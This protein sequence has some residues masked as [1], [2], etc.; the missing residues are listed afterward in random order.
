[1]HPHRLARFVDVTPPGAASAHGAAVSERLSRS[2]PGTNGQRA[3]V[4]LPILAV[5]GD[6]VQTASGPQRLG[7]GKGPTLTRPLM[8]PLI[9]ASLIAAAA[10]TPLAAAANPACNALIAGNVTLTAP[11]DCTN[12]ATHGL[13][14]SANTTLDCAG[15]TITGPDG[16]RANGAST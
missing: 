13:R 15:F 14:L 4:G 5:I 2:L 3:I 12:S 6:F 9:L 10:F 8:G 7:Q 16:A 1:A 11:M